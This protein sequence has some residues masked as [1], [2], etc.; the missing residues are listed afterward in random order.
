[1]IDLFC[2]F[3]VPLRSRIKSRFPV[4]CNN[5]SR[6]SSFFSDDLY[7]TFASSY[8]PHYPC[9]RSRASPWRRRS[10]GLSIRT[11]R[12]SARRSDPGRTSRCCCTTRGSRLSKHHGREDEG[13]K[14]RGEGGVR[15]QEQK[16]ARE[17]GNG[18]RR[19]VK[20][21]EDRSEW[22]YRTIHLWRDWGW[23]WGVWEV[24]VVSHEL[25]G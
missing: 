6:L 13:E 12:C 25:K 19:G 16:R 24:T 21:I 11:G 20:M 18:G 9:R 5:G 14:E 4:W 1:M 7:S 22:T 15:R 23:G 3:S 17:S 10:R 8:L 2:L